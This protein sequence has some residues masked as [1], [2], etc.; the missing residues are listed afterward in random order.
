MGDE[1]IPNTRQDKP[2]IAEPQRRQGVIL[3]EL[4][5]DSL[6]PTHRARVLWD[7]VSTLDLRA[8]LDGVK[9]VEHR[10][11]RPTLSPQMKLVLWLY[12][13]STGV[14]SAR[15]IARLVETDAAYRWI[16]GDRD[17]S[18]QTLSK[19]RVEHG[20][21]LDELMTDILAALL[22]KGVLSLD[23]VAQDGMRVRA[24]ASAPSFRRRESLERCREQAALHLKAVLAQADD[25]E[26]TRAQQAARVAA[27]RDFQQ[28]VDEAIATVVELKRARHAS[29]EPPRASTTDAE[30]RVMKMADGGFRPAYNV[31]TVT[32]GSPLGGPRTIV[33]VQVTNVGSDMGSIT[34]MLAEIKRRTGRLPNVL[35][36]DANHASHACIRAATDQNVTTL[37]AVPE[38]SQKPGRKADDDPSIAAWRARMETDEAKQVYRARASLCELTNAH[39]RSAYGLDRFLVRGLQK[40][41][42]VAL[43]AAIASN[44]LQHASTL[45]R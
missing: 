30:A 6:P 40:V 8:F 2:R 31:R 25:P 32:T 15:E 29:D 13:T 12:A 20:A 42:C 36:A 26:L 39:L 18:H 4:P 37:I 23:V 38:R 33:G 1:T 3:F 17:V 16:I 14:G 41:T 10:P 21:A 45:L 5:E 34:P 22:H 11:G 7:V 35:L 9:S 27:A 43:L 24:S 28:R 19:F 44:L